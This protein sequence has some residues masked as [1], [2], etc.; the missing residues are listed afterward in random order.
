MAELYSRGVHRPAGWVSRVSKRRRGEGGLAC[1]HRSQAGC[2]CNCRHT[3]QQSRSPQRRRLHNKWSPNCNKH[4]ATAPSCWLLR[5]SKLLG[6]GAHL[7]S[8][9]SMWCRILFLILLRKK[10]GGMACNPHDGEDLCMTCRTV[11]GKCLT[12]PVGTPS[13]PACLPSQISDIIAR[14]TF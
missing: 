14:Y 8:C 11:S 4:A 9:V 12:S 7:P 6:I 5:M 10:L 2:C 13:G 1:Q 3:L